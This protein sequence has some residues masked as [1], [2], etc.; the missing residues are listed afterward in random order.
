MEKPDV[1][2]KTMPFKLLKANWWKSKE[3]P[4]AKYPYR[5]FRQKKELEGET[6]NEWVFTELVKFYQLWSDVKGTR[7]DTKTTDIDIQADA[8]V[9]GKKMYLILNNM[10]TSA[11]TLNLNILNLDKNNIKS[12]TAKHL[13]EVNELPILD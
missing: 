5:L 6:G 13:Y 11:Q 1:M 3:F 10:E 2:L 4:N 12:I 8:Y 9:D 7:I